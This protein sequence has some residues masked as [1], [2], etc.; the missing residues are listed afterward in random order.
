MFSVQER[1][2]RVSGVET[3]PKLFSVQEEVT[4]RSMRQSCV[5]SMEAVSKVF[6]IQE[7]VTRVF[8]VKTVN[9]LFSWQEGVTVRSMM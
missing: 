8:W 3:L 4:V 1:V 7:R 9:K 2:R 5:S 6:S